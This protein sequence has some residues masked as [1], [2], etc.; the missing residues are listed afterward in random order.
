MNIRWEASFFELVDRYTSDRHDLDL[1]WCEENLSEFS[2]SHPS[3][4]QWMRTLS[5]YDV[6]AQTKVEELPF[7][8][9]YQRR[10]FARSRVARSRLN[11]LFDKEPGGPAPRAENFR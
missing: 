8:P 6:D 1:Q 11:E 4:E 9:L 2:R 5:L 7:Y 10:S 3:P